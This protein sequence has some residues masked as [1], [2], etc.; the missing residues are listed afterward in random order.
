MKQEDF[1]DLKQFVA[2]K[3]LAGRKATKKQL[4]VDFLRRKLG[5]ANSIHRD[6]MLH[7]CGLA[8]SRVDNIPNENC[9]GL[10]DFMES[11]E[12]LTLDARILLLMAFCG[13]TQNEINKFF[14]IHHR[15]LYRIIRGQEFIGGRVTVKKIIYKRKIIYKDR[16]TYKDRPRGSF[17][18]PAEELKNVL[19]VDDYIRKAVLYLESI[20][21]SEVKIAAKLGFTVR[22]LRNFRKRHDISLKDL[23]NFKKNGHNITPEERDRWSNRVRY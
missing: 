2:E 6:A 15:R 11:I 3:K 10:H 9:Q 22:T 4:Y 19:S 14:K 17:E 7:N 5:R 18:I 21:M 16:V 20:G 1:E 13:I 8:G 23:A 12:D